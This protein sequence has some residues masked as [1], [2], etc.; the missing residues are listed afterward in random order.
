MMVF[1]GFNVCAQS[2]NHVVLDGIFGA[3]GDSKFDMINN[4]AAMWCFSV[5]F[6][7]L[8]AFVFRWPVPVVYCI[9]NLDEIVKMPSVFMHY[10]KYIWLR[11]ITRTLE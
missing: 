10:R 4:V 9:V 6:G 7:L 8:A 3:G 2:I 11:N 5:P 1:C